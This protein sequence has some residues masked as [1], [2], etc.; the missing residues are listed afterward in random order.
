MLNY[1]PDNVRLDVISSLPHSIINEISCFVYYDK[2]PRDS[3][4]I[5][6]IVC[7]KNGEVKEFYRRELVG[8]L[9]IGTKATDIYIKRNSECEL[10]YVI[11]ADDNILILSRK[12]KPKV[13]HKIENVDRYEIEDSLCR[14]QARLIVIRKNDAV[15]LIFDEKFE[16]LGDKACLLSHLRVEEGSST[17]VTDLKRKLIEAKHTVK[18]NENIYKEYQNLRQLAAFSMYKKIHPNLEESVFKSGNKEMAGALKIKTHN[19]Y[20]KLCNNKVVIILNIFNEN[21]QPLEEVHLLLHIKSKPSIVYKTKLFVKLPISPHWNER[22]D[23]M[24]E[25]AETAVVAIVDFYDLKD[26]VVS[27]VE[28]SG[29]MVYQRA[30]NSHVLP[31]DTV[32]ISMNDMMGKDFDLLSTEVIDEHVILALLATTERTDL[33]LR[34]IRDRDETELQLHIPAV[35][36]SHLN[37]K[38][39]ED[40]VIAFRNSPYHPLNGITCI[41]SDPRDP[42]ESCYYMSIYSRF[43]SQVLLFNHIV[44]DSVPYKIIITGVN[45]KVVAKTYQFTEYNEELASFP[46]ELDY[47]DYAYAL[48]NQTALIKDH[49]DACLVHMNKS[50]DPEV[51]SK[52]GTEIDLYAAGTSTYQELR[53][54][55]LVEGTRGIKYLCNKSFLDHESEEL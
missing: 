6:I 35:L 39:Y 46:P 31:F 7:T 32:S 17:V 4:C 2:H 44:H 3:K 30:G 25:E 37:M 5:D 15:P 52:I 22:Y 24:I 21:E 9:N 26:M 27:Q 1:L 36:A 34:Y 28:F 49:L 54:E 23:F 11:I 42:M 18:C 20:I 41:F 16:M 47:T 43:P 55:L 51:L 14:G 45:Y 53:K 8:D 50:R 19:P 48:V 29:V 10:F 38:L 40:N 13:H 33:K 12:D